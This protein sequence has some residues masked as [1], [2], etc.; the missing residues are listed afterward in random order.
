MTWPLV[1]LGVGAVAGGIL[2]T[3]VEGRLPTFLEPVVG[4]FREGSAGL[5]TPILIGIALALTAAGLLI[6]WFAYGSG[7]IDWL[8][9]RVRLAPLHRL[10]QRGWYVDDAYAGVLGT[11]GK[12][13]AA[14]TAYV[15]DVRVI[16]GAVNGVG[17]LTRGL[18]NAG[19][20]VQTGLVRNYALG[21]LLGAVGI[22]LY[23]GLRF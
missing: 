1:V 21:L 8:A 6:T 22:L 11:P 12:A 9:L 7:K 5:I 10:L 17:I 4:R 3:G 19:R 13:A 15:F 20:R 18:A 14:F 23:V 2:A 16:D